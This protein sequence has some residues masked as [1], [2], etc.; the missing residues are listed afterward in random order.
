VADRP[1]GGGVSRETP[2]P[3]SEAAAVFG[4]RLGLA[5]RYAERLCTDGVE[6]GLLG[7]R[8]A[9]RIW[10]RHLLNCAVVGE[11]IPVGSRVVDVGSG[12]GLPGLALA[13][14]RPD[15]VVTLLEPMARRVTF[16]LEVVADLEIAGVDIR[17][18]RADEAPRRR[19]QAATARAVAPM[20]RLAEWSLP[21]LEPKGCLLALKGRSAREELTAAETA[22]RRLGASRWD[23]QDVG[24]GVIP[25]A[26]TVVRVWLDRTPED[27]RHV[28]SNR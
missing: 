21:L 15:L 4:G 19:W 11:L 14:A 23:V 17:R 9:P 10:D 2:R 6:R 24:V 26:A 22:L 18:A 16:L 3:P 27:P 1:T 7:P 12:A 20:Q 13:I 5:E 8:E 25:V 28:E